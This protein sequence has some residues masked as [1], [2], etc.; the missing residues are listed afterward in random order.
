MRSRVWSSTLALDVLMPLNF[1]EYG[2]QVGAGW[3]HTGI[4]SAKARGAE[5]GRTNAPAR[6]SSGF[7][8]PGQNLDPNGVRP[9]VS[10]RGT[11]GGVD[12]ASAVR[13]RRLEDLQSLEDRDPGGK[14][15]GARTV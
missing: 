6:P 11:A 3:N 1:G 8:D 13:R 7:G 4:V 15:S 2:V 10:L 9:S 5:T 12:R 14:T